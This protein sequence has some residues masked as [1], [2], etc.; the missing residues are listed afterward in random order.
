MAH[1]TSNPAD[2]QPAAD[3][4]G[5]RRDPVRAGDAAAALAASFGVADTA[6]RDTVAE[7]V[8]KFCHTRGHHG[9]DVAGL[10]YGTLE[11]TCPPETAAWL[12][13]DVDELT[14]ELDRAAAGRVRRVRILPRRHTIPSPTRHHTPSR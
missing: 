6:D 10:R 9:V 2:P 14:G 3:P 11:L 7:T 5:G 1:P 12:R 4:R 13:V 8:A